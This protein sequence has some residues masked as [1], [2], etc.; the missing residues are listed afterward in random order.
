MIR[1]GWGGKVV[2]EAP[3]ERIRD[4]KLVTDDNTDFYRA[5]TLHILGDGSDQPL[6]V[7]PGVPDPENF[8]RTI[9]CARDAWTPRTP[10]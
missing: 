2:G 10:A 7:L 3:L 9:L 1:K 5:A 4:V 6:L 8:R